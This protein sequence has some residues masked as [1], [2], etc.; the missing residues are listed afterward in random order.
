M[1]LS[2]AKSTDCRSR[3]HCRS[4]ISTCRVQ[5]W[6]G[7]LKDLSSSSN[8]KWDWVN[9]EGT[10]WN[11]GDITGV[12][13]NFWQG[14]PNNYRNRNEDWL[15]LD[16]REGAD[17]WR[18]SDEALSNDVNGYIGESVPAHEPATLILLGTG[19]IGLVGFSR[20]N[21]ENVIFKKVHL[22]VKST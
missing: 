4:V 11:N 16:Y 22:T 7:G 1:A 9:N 2:A 20:K 3:F 5:Y 13:S 17:D 6:L 10:F 15:A 21:E 8:E 19:L 14:E 12:Y 18:F